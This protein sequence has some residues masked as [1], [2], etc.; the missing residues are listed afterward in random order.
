MSSSREDLSNN[1]PDKLTL[2]DFGIETTDVNFAR[3]GNLQMQRLG[4]LAPQ[5]KAAQENKEESEKLARKYSE[6]ELK[7]ANQINEKGDGAALFVGNLVI[8]AGLIN[9]AIHQ[10][11]LVELQRLKEVCD[12][13]SHSSAF[14]LLQL[15]Q[16]KAREPR[17]NQA[18]LL[19]FAGLFGPPGGSPIINNNQPSPLASSPP[20]GAP[21]DNNK[22]YDSPRAR[23]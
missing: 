11:D 6:D 9:T 21:V 2:L 12:P 14:A 13:K 5:L 17:P 22:A 23:K 1:Q 4:R 10:G 19:Q 15:I 3:I 8:L 7:I 20:G 18:Q 16:S